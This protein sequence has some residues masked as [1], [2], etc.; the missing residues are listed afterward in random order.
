MEKDSTIVHGC[1]RFLKERLYE[2]SDPYQMPICKECG[3]DTIIEEHCNFCG[4]D[5]LKKIVI[6]Y[7]TKL[8]RTELG[9]MCIKMKPGVEK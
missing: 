1:S 7:A 8:L 4:S 5:Q 3:H 9:A 6:P 2:M